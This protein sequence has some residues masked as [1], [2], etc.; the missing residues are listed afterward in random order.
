MDE[1][2]VNRHNHPMM[3][4]ARKESYMAGIRDGYRDGYKNG[5]EQKC[6]EI[7]R[8]YRIII[9]ALERKMEVKLK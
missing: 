9:Q 4:K 6:D 7:H 3:V 5:Y 8:Y 1:K 2:K